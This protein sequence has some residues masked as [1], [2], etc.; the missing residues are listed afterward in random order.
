M[1]FRPQSDKPASL[2][3]VWDI[4]PQHRNRLT[5]SGGKTPFHRP[6]STAMR[7]ISICTSN[8]ALRTQ[9]LAK[10]CPKPNTVQ[11]YLKQIIAQELETART[12][13]LGC[14]R[15]RL[16]PPGALWGAD[17]EWGHIW[18]PDPCQ[19]R[20]KRSQGPRARDLTQLM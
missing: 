11:R 4:S 12:Q 9:H 14:S 8:W 1:E 3:L 13:I 20:G 2:C 15:H 16:Q 19:Y 6:R 17:C 7:I 5:S 18:T 10:S